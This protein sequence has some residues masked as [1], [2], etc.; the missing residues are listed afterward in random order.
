MGSDQSKWSENRSLISDGHAV[1][2]PATPDDRKT[3]PKTVKD[4]VSSS[5]QSLLESGNFADVTVKCGA[6]TWN[7]HRAILCPRCPYFAKALSGNFKE[8]Q[9]REVM[10]R[11]ADMD[12]RLLDWVIKYLYTGDLSG[13]A[14]FAINDGPGGLLSVCWSM[15][16]AADY[17]NINSLTQMALKTLSA[18]L[19]E[20]AASIQRQCWKDRHELRSPECYIP[21]EYLDSF[22]DMVSSAYEH[23]YVRVGRI[24]K[25]LLR[26]IRQ[27]H[28]ILVKDVRFREHLQEVPQFGSDLF[29]EFCLDPPPD[30]RKV[31]TRFPSICNTCKKNPLN[32]DGFDSI[33]L[34]TA[35]II[36]STDDPGYS[37]KVVDED[38]FQL[39]ISAQGLCMRCAR[40]PACKPKDPI[41]IE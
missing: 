3:V 17:F 34:E 10:I 31:L 25:M 36:V 28:F 21:T 16:A 11:E 30:Q 18:R 41:V 8:A 4:M 20:T 38:G 15:F 12:P 9:T 35:R 33:W 14:E 39:T 6:R 2:I 26:F 19:L 1:R 29:T 7:L 27:T 32:D 22:F 23:E 37:Q 13:P 40:K 5:D 24:R